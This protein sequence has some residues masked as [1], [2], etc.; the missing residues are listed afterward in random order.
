M[1]TIR[2]PAADRIAA[3][4]EAQSAAPLSYSPVGLSGSECDGFRHD[5]IRESV[6]RG[7]HD[8]ASA[9]EALRTWKAFPGGW[10]EVFPA[11]A[12]LTPDTTVAVLA[13][14]LGFWSLNACR[15]V[16]VFEANPLSF[17][18]A[19]G[20]L[21][22]HVECGEERFIV[23]LDPADHSVWYEIRATSRPRAL[24]PRLGYPVSRLL[25]AWFRRESIR[26][27]KAAIAHSRTRRS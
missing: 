26:A 24:L 18:F 6:G 23:E 10:V 13:R 19:Y 22:E 16:E 20:T 17:G 11:A 4:L 5:V 15:V 3:F 9:K 27:M 14:H 1:F 12:A 21:V 2:R 8:F 7:E 25:Q